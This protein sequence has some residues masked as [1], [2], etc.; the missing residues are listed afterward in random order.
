MAVRAMTSLANNKKITSWLTVKSYI[1]PD[2]SGEQDLVVFCGFAFQKAHQTLVIESRPLGEGGGGEYISMELVR[3][4]GASLILKYH[5]VFWTCVCGI[6]HVQ[7]CVY[8][9]LSV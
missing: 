3:V 9:L 8:L 6:Q 4:Q 2:S 7:G 5:G 1:G